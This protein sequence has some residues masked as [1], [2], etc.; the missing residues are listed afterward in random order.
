MPRQMQRASFEIS[1]MNE[2]DITSIGERIRR[3]VRGSLPKPLYSRCA[4]MADGW[5]GIRHFGLQ[6]YQEPST[7]SRGSLADA[8]VPVHL[9]QLPS[10]FFVRPGTPDA[11]LVLRRR[12]PERRIL[13]SFLTL[14]FVE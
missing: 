3:V 7:F 1:E 11:S 5:Y 2:M 12:S 10:P 6:E 14:L 9:R 4:S 8:P 13:T